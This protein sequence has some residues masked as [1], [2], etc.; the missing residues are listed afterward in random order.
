[1]GL[2]ISFFE[3]NGVRILQVECWDWCSDFVLS[4]DIEKCRHVG[5]RFSFRLSDGKDSV[6]G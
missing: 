3:G 4:F 2:G 5:V 6:Y 1:M